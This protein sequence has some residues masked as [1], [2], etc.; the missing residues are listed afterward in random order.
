MHLGSFAIALA[1]ISTTLLRTVSGVEVTYTNK[2]YYYFDIDG[3]AIDST[4]G[5]V[6][7]IKDQY[8]WVS[9]PDCKS[10]AQGRR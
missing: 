8:F 2:H 3:N 6:E 9:E 4:N 5:K 7:W 1:A 10:R